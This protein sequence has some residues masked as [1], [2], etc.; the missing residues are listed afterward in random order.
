M[1]IKNKKRDAQA[2]KSR[3]SGGSVISMRVAVGM[4]GGAGVETQYFASQMRASKMDV[5]TDDGVSH[6]RR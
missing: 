6:H 3:T 5:V 1:K 4:V 2:S